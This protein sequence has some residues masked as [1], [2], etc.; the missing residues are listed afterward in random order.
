[1]F[2]CEICDTLTDEKEK[3]KTI[4]N[5]EVKIISCQTCAAS[6]FSKESKGIDKNE[7]V[8]RLQDK[9]HSLVVACDLLQNEKAIDALQKAI[10][11]LDDNIS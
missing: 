4:S 5:R 10:I 2:F 9:I 7:F 11:E 6:L 8:R 3:A 1:M